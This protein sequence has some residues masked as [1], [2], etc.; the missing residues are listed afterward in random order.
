[1]YQLSGNQQFELNLWLKDNI[2][3]FDGKTRDE[4]ADLAAKVFG[5]RVTAANIDRARKDTGCDWVKAWGGSPGRPNKKIDALEERVAVLEEASR[6]QAATIT[7]I[8]DVMKDQPAIHQLRE[9]ILERINRKR[10]QS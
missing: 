4:V 10:A 7:A 5:H 9:Q 1:M 2:A 3:N 8:L 6:E